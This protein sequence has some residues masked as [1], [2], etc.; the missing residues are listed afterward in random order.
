MVSVCEKNETRL[1]NAMPNLRYIST[2]G[3]RYTSQADN[4]AEIDTVAQACIT[5]LTTPLTE[6]ESYSGIYELPPE[7]IYLY[8]GNSY[9]EAMD[10]YQGNLTRSATIASAEFTD[11]SPIQLPT[12][13]LVEKML[14]GTSHA[15]DEVVGSLGPLY[16]EATV[17]IV[18][19]NGVMAGC[20]PESMPLLLALT[21]CLA[22]TDIAEANAGAGGWFNFAVVVNGPIAQEISLNDG[23]P[24]LSGPA[25]LTPGVPANTSIGRF[26]RLMMINVGGT[27][28]GVLEGKGTGNP[29]KTSIVLAED[30]QSPWPAFSSSSAIG[31]P[32]G[33]STVSLFVTWGDIIQGNNS[34]YQG[35][36]S[37]D[38][39]VL[40]QEILGSDVEA[41]KNLSRPQQGLVLFLTTPKAQALAEAGFTREDVQHWISTHCVDTYAD[42]SARGLGKGVAGTVFTIQGKPIWETGSWPE[43]WSAPDFDPQTVVQW[44]PH[45]EAISVIVG[46]RGANS[47]LMNGNPRWSVSVEP[48]R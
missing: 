6:E 37:S 40:L 11:G 43:E 42:A 25:P 38:E 4:E 26:L 17:K 14:A 5:A 9:E 1:S 31:L 15:P 34:I 41:A 35:P 2:N 24:D 30:G 21:E 12:E 47:V 36:Q 48:W 7:P 27:E 44:F 39:E 32:D 46:L 29:H 20:E 22:N 10:A 33:E 16:N 28:P 19:I 8:Q 23:G 18:A 13:E 3:T 45:E